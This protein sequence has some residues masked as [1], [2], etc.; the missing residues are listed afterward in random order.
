LKAPAVL[1][2]TE[3]SAESSFT[4]VTRAPGGTVTSVY[5]NPSIVIVGPAAAGGGDGLAVVASVVVVVV[6]VVVS[7]SSRLTFEPPQ[8]TANTLSRHAAALAVNRL[9][10]APANMA[11]LLNPQFQPHPYESRHRLR[12][13]W[14]NRLGFRAHFLS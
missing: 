11:L 1:D 5:L 14:V 3:C 9:T 12:V 8:A 13:E 10:L 4:T 2:V 7:A 6:A